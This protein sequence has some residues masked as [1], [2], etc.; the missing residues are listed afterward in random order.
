[1][2]GDSEALHAVEALLQ[3]CRRQVSLF[4]YVLTPFVWMVSLCMPYRVG[5]SKEVVVSVSHPTL[6][7]CGSSDAPW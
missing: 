1:M 3:I 5:A 6:S 4:E 2:A 7:M